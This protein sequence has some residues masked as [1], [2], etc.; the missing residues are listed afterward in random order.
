MQRRKELSK[1]KLIRLFNVAPRA[2][3]S[4]SN[5][6]QLG[7]SNSLDCEKLLTLLHDMLKVTTWKQA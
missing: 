3:A 5:I 1:L 4:N 2:F 6:V 7:W